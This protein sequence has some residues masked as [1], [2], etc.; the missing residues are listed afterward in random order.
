M[1]EIIGA[2]AFLAA[3]YAAKKW[4]DD[5]DVRSAH[6][7]IMQW[8]GDRARFM[9]LTRYASFDEWLRDLPDNVFENK[10]LL[11]RDALIDACLPPV[12]MLNSEPLAR[13]GVFLYESWQ[14]EIERE[15]DRRRVAARAK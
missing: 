6:K 15:L 12:G 7:K 4:F 9:H 14:W 2:I 1:N 13:L 5:H 11:A 8:Q 10:E 3:L